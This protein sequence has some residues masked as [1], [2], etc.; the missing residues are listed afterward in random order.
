M[1]KES[2]STDAIALF[3]LPNCDRISASSLNI[4]QLNNLKISLRK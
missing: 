4:Q 3:T 2:F 1:K